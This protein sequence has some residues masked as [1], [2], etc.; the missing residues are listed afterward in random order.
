ML[1]ALA[2]LAG[3]IL[4]GCLG[5][6]EVSPVRIQEAYPDATQRFVNLVDGD[7]DAV[8][9][10]AIECGTPSLVVK[11]AYEASGFA[12]FELK[13]PSEKTVRLVNV[14]QTKFTRE[15]DW[16]RI[17]FPQRG[18]WTF[19]LKIRDGA[20]YTFAFYFDSIPTIKTNISEEEVV[21]AYADADF[22]IVDKGNCSKEA[23]TSFEIPA[24]TARLLVRA[25][26]YSQQLTSFKLT[27]P[28]IPLYDS[29]LGGCINRNAQKSET[30]EPATE[31]RTDSWYVTENPRPGCW[32]FQ[33]DPQGHA[34]F[35]FGFYY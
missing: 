25:T 12:S 14:S 4:S 27:P 8:R 30:A 1:L 7:E 13:D 21:N 29:Q 10:I 33:V 18:T 24:G 6:D 26:Y 3:L 22:R 17:E 32:T 5:E 34:R 2:T 19:T 31:V 23:S 9:S 16:Y 35:A 28:G 11:A 15:D 20:N